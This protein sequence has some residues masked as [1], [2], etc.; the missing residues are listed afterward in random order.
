M[1]EMTLQGQLELLR[2]YI[3]KVDAKICH[4]KELYRSIKASLPWKLP[5]TL[6]KDLVAYAVAQ[7]NIQH[8][9]AINWNMCPSLLFTGLKVNYKELELGFGDDC[10]LFDGTDNTSK[11][12]TIPGI[13]LCPSNITMG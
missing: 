2:S 9:S 5:K 7:I 6:V 13:A 10:E 3:S 4:I 12:N 11:S 1:L 8:T